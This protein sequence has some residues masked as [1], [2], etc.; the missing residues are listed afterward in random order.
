MYV[1]VHSTPIIEMMHTQL[2]LIQII[3]IH[4]V[5]LNFIP[6]DPDFTAVFISRLVNR[7]VTISLHCISRRSKLCAIV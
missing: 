7:R 2:V 4:K 5:R 3:Q 1:Y 6:I